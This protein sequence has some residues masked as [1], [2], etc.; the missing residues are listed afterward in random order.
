M[1]KGTDSEDG[2]F[3]KISKII[4][5]AFCKYADVFRNFEQL[6]V[7]YKVHTFCCIWEITHL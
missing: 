7:Y 2:Y 3:L 1:F 6:I 4:L 5:Y